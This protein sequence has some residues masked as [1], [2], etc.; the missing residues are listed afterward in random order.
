MI[1]FFPHKGNLSIIKLYTKNKEK[2]NSS[3]VFLFHKQHNVVLCKSN[4]LFCCLVKWIFCIEDFLL[5][6]VDI[7]DD[8]KN[9]GT[10]VQG[11]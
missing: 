7:G 11:C 3:S 4:D 9:G 1:S 5:L 2:W 8:D 10:C 6:V